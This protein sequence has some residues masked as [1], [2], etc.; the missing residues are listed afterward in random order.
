MFIRK[1][2]TR[3]TGDTVYRAV[4]LVDTGSRLARS[5]HRHR[6]PESRPLRPKGTCPFCFRERKGFARDPPSVN[7]EINDF[8]TQVTTVSRRGVA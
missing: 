2:V 4:R 7:G 1:T 5:A 6:R 3:R 8:P